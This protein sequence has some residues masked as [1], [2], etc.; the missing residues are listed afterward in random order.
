MSSLYGTLVICAA[1]IAMGVFYLTFQR[2]KPEGRRSLGRQIAA[3]CAATAMAALVALLGCLRNGTA[4][5]WLL[6]AGL[7]ACTIADGVLCVRF[8]PGGAIFALGHVLYMAS[9][10]LMNRPDWRSAILFLVLAGM[11]AA[12]LAR[13]RVSPGRSLPLFIAYAAI[14]SMMVALAAVQPP[15]FFAG[16]LLFA[17]SDGLLAFLLVK[18]D[19][20]RL[21]YTSLALYYLGQFLL[22]LAVWCG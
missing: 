8:I 5:H 17:I 10:C 19:D 16:A 11:A 14:L 4:A 12:G 3:K 2:L 9:F 7:I 6:L 18:G 21:D 15:L 20:K 13:L 1:F 22:G